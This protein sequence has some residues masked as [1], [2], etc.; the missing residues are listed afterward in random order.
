MAELFE[1]T[2]ILFSK[3]QEYHK[4]TQGDKK[5]HFFMINRR[6]SINFP[7]QAQLL[8]HIRINDAAVIDF[9]QAFL[10][11]QYSK[12]PGWMFVKGVK[13]SNEEK[14]KTVNIKESALKEY[15]SYFGY[16][17][18]SVKEAAIIFP[19]EFKKEINNFEKIMNL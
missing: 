10:S 14:E 6:M 19:E 13:K 1:L 3:P 8:Q 7:L 15:A 16:D 18:K 4:V 2:D 9:W 11:K 5:K 17:L 12:T